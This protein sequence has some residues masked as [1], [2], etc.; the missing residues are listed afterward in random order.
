[1]QAT[2]TVPAIRPALQHLRFLEL[3]AERRHDAV[4]RLDVLDLKPFRE[5]IDLRGLQ[6]ETTCGTSRAGPGKR[7]P[8]YNGPVRRRP[9]M[10]EV[11]SK[12][13]AAG[14]D[15][16]C[17]WGAGGLAARAGL[18]GGAGRLRRPCPVHDR[19]L[20]GACCRQAAAGRRARD[21]GGA[22]RPRRG[23]TRARVCQ[24]ETGADRPADRRGQLRSLSGR[25]ALRRV[26]STWPACGWHWPPRR[27]TWPPCC[28]A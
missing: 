17:G 24:E 22:W 4:C 14:S 28:A 11:R 26:P 18:A 9:T 16:R 10:S 13:Q 1:M 19:V 25:G 23:R 8:C 2:V 20:P 12:K 5:F 3:P 7:R 6:A 21:A 27:R 15:F